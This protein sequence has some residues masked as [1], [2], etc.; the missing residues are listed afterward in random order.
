MPKIICLIF[1]NRARESEQG[2]APKGFTCSLNNYDRQSLEDSHLQR[3]Y[4]KHEFC[5]IR[6]A[7]IEAARIGDEGVDQITEAA[8]RSRTAI[9]ARQKVLV[10][11]NRGTSPRRLLAQGRRRSL[12]NGTIS[13]HSRA[14]ARYELKSTETINRA[15]NS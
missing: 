5:P 4:S 10:V 3:N 15:K 1:A 11:R 13:G 12:D 6:R 9:E 14:Y 8:R 7:A 2:N